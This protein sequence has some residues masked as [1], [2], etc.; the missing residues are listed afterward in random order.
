[1]VRIEATNV[2]NYLGGKT[3]SLR[4][5]QQVQRV[6]GPLD[7]LVVVFFRLRSFMAENSANAQTKS[8]KLY[9]LHTGE[10][11]E[12]TFKKNGQY[13]ASGL[14]K[15]NWHLARL[16]PQ[17]ADQDGS[18]NCWIWSGKPT[19]NPVR[20]LIFMLSQ[21]TARLPRTP[22]CASE[23][24]ALRKTHNTPAARRWISFCPMSNS[25]KC[26]KSA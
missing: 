26:V 15:I 14:K 19:A 7:M 8:L 22:C 10:K 4:F 6:F 20:K 9:Y 2:G 3:Y 21:D 11:A 13:L 24:A 12:I 16:A 1:M 25:R 18:R 5:Y 17:R 23:A